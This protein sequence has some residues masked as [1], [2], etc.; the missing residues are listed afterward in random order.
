MEEISEKLGTWF[1]EA[2]DRANYLH[3]WGFH[4]AKLDVIAVER[5][6]PYVEK[7]VNEALKIIFGPAQDRDTE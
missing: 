7:M 5:R 4:E 2:W 1:E 6:A 3:A